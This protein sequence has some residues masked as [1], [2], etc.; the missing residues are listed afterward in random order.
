MDTGRLIQDI[1]TWF[2]MRFVNRIAARLF[3]RSVCMGIADA[4]GFISSLLPKGI[5]SFWMFRLAFGGDKWQALRLNARSHARLFRDNMFMQRYL[6]QKYDLSEVELTSTNL[7]KV[8]EIVESGE[9]VILATLHFSR[10]A[11]LPYYLRVSQLGNV[12]ASL[13]DR[14]VIS[15]GFA[16]RMHARRLIEQFGSMAD[17]L[18]RINPDRLE[19]LY[20]GPGQSPMKALLRSL[21]DSG[22][23]V[24]ITVDAPWKSGGRGVINRPFCGY[25]D[26][27][28]STGAARLART[29]GRPI[30]LAIPT[31]TDEGRVHL[32]FG[33][34]LTIGKDDEA[35]EAQV[36]NQ[37]LDEIERYV[38]AY[39][40]QYVVPLGIGRRWNAE[41]SRWE[42]GTY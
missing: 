13:L 7:E 41:S 10:E 5:Q 35:A 19:M 24:M 38:G 8:R 22:N 16:E 34:P 36:M 14:P 17:V 15:G 32:H 37:L 26:R 31:V 9:S 40:E 21:R 4:L 12:A 29:T 39:P 11:Q 42:E 1:Y 25:P 18:E 33:D 27:A 6:A 2:G 30:I 28:F 20:V 23:M 3:P